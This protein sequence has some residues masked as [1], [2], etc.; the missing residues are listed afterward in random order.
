MIMQVILANGSFERAVGANWGASP[1][2]SEPVVQA[3]CLWLLGGGFGYW[4][5]GMLVLVLGADRVVH[6]IL[7]FGL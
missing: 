3:P 1:E 5:G 7:G 4:A 2:C 6:V